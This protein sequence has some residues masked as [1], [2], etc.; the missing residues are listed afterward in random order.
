MNFYDFYNKVEN[1]LTDSILSLWATGN[2]ELQSYL[3]FLISKDPLLS[4]VVFQNTFPWTPDKLTFAETEGIFEKSFINSLDKI[5]NSEFKFPKD[6]HPY[7]HQV[8]SWRELLDNKRSIAVTT[9]TGSGKTECFMLPVLHDIYINSKDQVGVNA[10]FLYPLNALIASQRKRMHAWCSALDGINYALLTG[11]TVERASSAD[12]KK[13]AL[14]QL[15]SREQI[16]ETPPQVLFT[17]PTMLEY[18]LVRNADAPILDKSKGKLR[19]ILLDEAHTLTGSKAA[20]M[21]LLIR[22]VISSFEVSSK[23]IRFAI[24]SA[25]VG[26]GNEDT[27]KTFMAKLCGITKEQISVIGG[28]RVLPECNWDSIEWKHGLDRNKVEKIR[29]NFISNVGYTQKEVGEKLN[30]QSKEE[31]IQVMDYL[32]DNSFLPLR[33]HYFTRGIGG[34]YVCTN[35]NCNVHADN[36]PSSVLGTIH[37]TAG[38]NCSCGYPLLEMISCRNCGHILLEGE[39]VSTS[40]GQD[41]IRQKASVGYEAFSIEDDFDEDIQVDEEEIKSVKSIRFARLESRFE[42]S[43]FPNKAI[44]KDG[45][46]KEGNDFILLED[47]KCPYCGNSNDHPKYFRLSSAFTN[48][49]LSDIILQQTKTVNTITG[50]TLCDGKKYISF[51]DSRQGTAKISALINIDSETNWTRY[52]VY[53]YLLKKAKS[54]NNNIDKVKREELE[55]EKAGYEKSLT[56]VPP[57]I[58]EIV[59]NKINEIEEKLNPN[60]N[61]HVKSRSTWRELNEE[62]KKSSD[63]KTLFF[64]SA[65]GTDF[66]RQGDIYTKSLLFD[67]FARRKPQERSLENIGLINLTYPK[68]ENIIRPQVAE[69]LDI[70]QSEWIDLLKISCDYILRYGFHFFLDDSIRQF[71]TVFWRSQPIYPIDTEIEK[72]SVWPKL[73][74]KSIQHRFVLL[75]C[76]GLGYTNRDD[77]D[78]EVEDQINELLHEIWNTLIRTYVLESDGNGF[79]I[80]LEE[81]TTFELASN[82]YLCPVTNRLIDKIFRN[83]SPWIKGNLEEQNIENY[84]LKNL[85][86]FEFPIYEYPDSKTSDNLPV[87]EEQIKE[88]FASNSKPAKDLGLWNDLHER[89]FNFGK[90]YLAGEHSAQQRK[91]RL[92]ELE[93]EFEAGEINILSC[94]TTMEMGV[95]IGGISAVVMS[96]VPPMPANYLQRTGRAGRRGERKSLALTFCAPNPIGLRAM[97]NPKWALEHPIAPPILSFDSKQIAER[98]VNSLLLGLYLR[99]DDN[100]KKG[101][102]I[103]QKLEDFFFRETPTIGEGF[104]SWMESLDKMILESKETIYKQIK[105]LVDETPIQTYP[106]GVLVKRVMNDFSRLVERTREIDKTYDQKLVELK[107]EYGENS[108]A[109]KSVRYRKKQFND[110]FVL[111]Y[112]A[113]EGFLPN[114]GLPT[115]IVEFDNTSIQDL[116]KRNLLKSNPSYP[117]SRA[118]TEFAPG[119]KIVIDGLSYESSGIVM[120]T[121][122]DSAKIEIVQACT[123]CGYQRIKNVNEDLQN[124]P[125]CNNENTL[126]GLNLGENKGRFTEVIEP[127]GFS[128]DLFRSPSRVINDRRNPQYLEPLLINLEPW[129]EKQTSS[130]DFRMSDSDDNTEILFYNTGLGNGYSVCLD[131]GRVGYSHEELSGHKRLRGGKDSEGKS[132]CEGKNIKD[133]V[134]LGSRFKTDFIE[135]RLL[136]SDGILVNDKTM[137]YSLGTTFTKSLAKYLGI[138]ENELGF[139]TKKYNSYQTIFI[140]DTAKGGAGY[141]YLFSRYIQE[142]I[143]DS[144]KTL[145]NCDCETVCT[146]CMIDRN[147]QWHIEDLDRHKAIEW[148]MMSKRNE[149][150]N[151]LKKLSNTVRPVYGSL[152]KE[153]HRINYFYGIKEI[154]LHCKNQIENWNLEELPWIRRH[155]LNEVKLSIVSEGKFENLNNEEKFTIYSLNAKGIEL[156]EGTGQNINSFKVALLLVTSDGKVFHYLTTGEL[157]NLNLE[158]GEINN[159]R[160]ILIEDQEVVNLQKIEM[161]SF[162]SITSNLFESN[163]GDVSEPIQTSKLPQL[164]IDSLIN[165]NS[166]EFISQIKDQKYKVFYIDKY[167]QSEFSLRLIIQFLDSFRKYTAIEIEEFTVI[168]NDSDF[169]STKSI[170]RMIDNYHTIDEYE[171]DLLQITENLSFPVTLERRRDKL[172]HYRLFEFKSVNREFILRIDGGIAHGFKP[173]INR[174]PL[175]N[176]IFNIRKDVYHDIIYNVRIV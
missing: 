77:I 89:T 123:K 88:W 175:R 150:P 69:K 156:L 100:T 37:L 165:K 20:E 32:A 159:S 22:R 55:K 133:H 108:P 93:Q 155:L 172:P 61:I 65:R 23:D 40:K 43:D 66:I 167:N 25:T 163:I 67:Q 114:A 103:R 137:L 46:L 164:M 31:Q 27:L 59:I 9:G 78:I 81:N 30:L 119:N 144:L 118:L 63:L 126:E 151:D 104:L 90:L 24:T 132:N 57:N 128:M 42:K 99:S 130:I 161:P 142:I 147:T 110:N 138:E 28:S 168:L 74:K 85:N 127:A 158:W 36:R 124:C 112:L 91:E 14:P 68:L 86:S 17:N 6:R 125:K 131:C 12:E 117:I 49:I 72:V 73:T 58:K 19:W 92:A 105:S 83:Y 54:G 2:K 146:K 109:F 1:R 113:E 60:L 160:Y 70:K 45:K 16:R 53:H 13:K 135:L 101:L 71:S 3:R 4:D 143:E 5:S 140:Y 162:E 29:K 64:K 11:D 120:E 173:V 8:Q 56:I 139:G 79:K 47:N 121:L 107:N 174:L 97:N 176:E 52:R 82:V 26:T 15:I 145:Q 18:M 21:A 134:I 84:L 95:D 152:T 157:Q 102:N 122:W 7:Q 48:R 39:K 166:N 50:K 115:G 10:L 116:K 35:S 141:S 149:I 129:E 136:D 80:N 38:K 171:K 111:K 98:H 44:E 34:A 153:I 169:K 76:A 170:I 148:L 106:P 75:I 33:A 41:L 62:I 87:N 51:T 94:S 154:R 96:N